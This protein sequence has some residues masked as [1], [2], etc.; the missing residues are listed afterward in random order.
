MRKI[1]IALTLLVSAPAWAEWVGMP[2][3]PFAL[4]KLDQPITL[5]LF[6]NATVKCTK[7]EQL[8]L[9]PE[10]A[11]A[12]SEQANFY[13]EKNSSGKARLGIG[14]DASDLKI[15]FSVR[16]D[17]SGL[18]K[19]DPEIES[20]AQ[21]TSIEKTQLIEPQRAMLDIF[22]DFYNSTLG[23]S[24]QQDVTIP[25]DLPDI[26]A[27]FVG[28]PG[29]RKNAST[30]KVLGK[31]LVKNRPTLIAHGESKNICTI[32]NTNLQID[33]NGWYAFDIAS[34]LPT[35]RY[36]EVKGTFP[37]LGVV[38]AITTY[39]C[40]FV[41]SSLPASP[42]VGVDRAI[43]DRLRELKALYEK[44]LITKDQFEKRSSQILENL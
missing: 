27:V 30:L 8:N 19:G 10:K 13:L 34:G 41:G 6:P 17:G 21:M 11:Q 26:C 38:S 43:E 18:V 42:K 15:F 5:R 1:L 7:T 9:G 39:D 28:G 32:Q 22:I 31:T 36:E 23:K 4:T 16:T 2:P 25:W 44:G 35:S 29:V 14:L 12:K 20:N 37:A 24:L 40:N 33:S 3:L